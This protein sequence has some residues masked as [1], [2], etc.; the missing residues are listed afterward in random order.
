MAKQNLVTFLAAIAGLYVTISVGWLVCQQRVSTVVQMY[1]IYV[2]NT[3]HG[4][5]H[6]NTM[7]RVQC[8]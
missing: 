6:K 5:Q 8:I 7:Y 4:K 1:M 3:M 2:Y